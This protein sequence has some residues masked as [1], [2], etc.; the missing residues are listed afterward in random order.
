MLP[1]MAE[2]RARVAMVIA[3]VL[4]NAGLLY[5]EWRQVD[6]TGAKLFEQRLRAPFSR[7]RRQSD[8]ARKLKKAEAETVFEAMQ[9]VDG[10]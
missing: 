1:P 3:L 8:E 6:P 9:A 4:V 7:L 2:D 10:G 5:W